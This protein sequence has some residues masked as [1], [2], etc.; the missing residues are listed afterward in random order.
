MR[1]L[2]LCNVPLPVI[3]QHMGS[4][5][6]P[7][8]GWLE[9]MSKALLKHD[10][11]ELTVIFLHSE[12]R[13][14]NAEGIRY[15]TVTAPMEQDL[16]AMQLRMSTIIADVK[17]DVV[18]IFGTECTHTLA[19]LKACDD[20]A[21]LDK[22]VVSIQGLVSI[23]AQHYFAGLPAHI[24]RR[25]TLY[26]LKHEAGMHH[27][28][29]Y[30]YVK[31]GEKEHQALRLAKHV[32]GRT[33][34]DRACAEHINPDISYHLC[35]ETLRDSF[36]KARWSLEECERHSIFV[37]QCSYPLKGFHRMLE[38]MPM[39]LRSY[40]NAMLYT[41]GESPLKAKGW[42]ESQR[43]NY[44]QLYLAKRIR[45]LGLENNVRFL[46]RLDETQMREQYLRSN[47]FVC[48]S[49][50]E[51]SS[52][53]IGEAM[54]LGMPVVAS[55]VGG[56]KNLLTH[57]QE[58]LIYPFDENYMLAYYVERVFRDE[59]MAQRMGESAHARAAV[60]HDPELNDRRLMEIYKGIAGEM[61]HSGG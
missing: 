39:V 61:M 19:M 24:T 6:N 45:E 28:W 54:L 59:A 32:I 41:T 57:G 16:P 36:Y 10:D 12:L 56:V 44:Y 55:D 18:H 3:S 30:Y 38:A 29:Q 5:V 60:T 43:L 27:H 20:A 7:S 23:C 49:S 9:G 4:S 22:T 15:H 21:L 58:G 13:D 26:D 40:P 53:S 14:G 48:C 46:G 42:L 8:G 37:S 50:I 2:W 31:Q 17:P 11:V 34:W 1:V 33:D 35:N 51:N 52:N 25:V 47:V